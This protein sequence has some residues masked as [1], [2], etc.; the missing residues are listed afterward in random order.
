MVIATTP[1]G[2]HRPDDV[3]ANAVHVM[4][5]ATGQINEDR[6]I[7]QGDPEPAVDKDGAN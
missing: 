4:R 1:S 7:P 6:H 5:I 3:V 2:K